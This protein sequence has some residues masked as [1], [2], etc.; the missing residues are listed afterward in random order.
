MS[1]LSTVGLIGG[2]ENRGFP[3]GDA[4]RESILQQLDRILAHPTFRHS[5]RYPNLLRHIVE[6]ALRG[7]G[8]LKERTLGVEVFGRDPDYDT[9]EDPIVRIAAG[10]IRKRIA[11]YYHEPG[12]E[13]ELQIDLP[14]GSYA[15]EFRMPQELQPFEQTRLHPGQASGFLF[16]RTRGF[17][18]RRLFIYSLIAIACVAVVAGTAHVKAWTAENALE[19]FWYP[20]L[21]SPESALVCVGEPGSANPPARRPVD[22]SVADHIYDASDHIAFSDANAL[23]RLAQFLGSRGKNPRLEAATSTSL[24]DLRQGPIVLVAGFDNAWTLRISQP[25]RY[26]FGDSPDL[27]VFWIADR[28]KPSKR[29]WSVNFS[30]KYSQLTQDYAIVSRFSDPTTGE[31]VVVAAGLGENGTTAAG[32][33]LTDES[34]MESATKHAPRNWRNKNIEVVIATQVIG[35]SSGPPSVIATYYW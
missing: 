12:R 10:E 26:H 8:H 19:N 3:T 14:S 34:E 5:K 18:G 25:L 9:N 27:K 32:E 29:N 30:E 22:F 2:D 1:H 28:D 7:E 24:T 6:H 13:K 20:V 4:E 11:Q 23:F 21:R 35:G 16:A 33:F 15:P 17:F 31:P